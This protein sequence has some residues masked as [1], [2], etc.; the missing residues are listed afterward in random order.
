MSYLKT[1]SSSLNELDKSIAS[2]GMQMVINNNI[3]KAQTL[4]QKEKLV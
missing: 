3:E 1:N 4:F 2:D